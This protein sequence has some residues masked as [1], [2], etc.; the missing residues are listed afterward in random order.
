MNQLGDGPQSTQTEKLDAPGGAGGAGSV[1][2][3]DEG[4]ENLSSTGKL[5]NRASPFR[6][7]FSYSRIQKASNWW[8]P[9]SADYRKGLSGSGDPQNFKFF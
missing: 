8:S 3:A 9:K 6:N 4:N 1:D 2:G 7:G 5:K